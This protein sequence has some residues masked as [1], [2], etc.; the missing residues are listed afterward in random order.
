MC[1]RRRPARLFGDLR[2]HVA[3]T[4]LRP[5]AEAAEPPAEGFGVDGCAAL[6]GRF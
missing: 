4:G 5:P 1:G 6:A 3:V 2:F